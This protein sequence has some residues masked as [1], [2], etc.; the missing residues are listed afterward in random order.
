M[1]RTQYVSASV[2]ALHSASTK[3]LLAFVYRIAR[4]SV[5]FRPLETTLPGDGVTVGM[6]T[7]TIVSIASL[8][9]RAILYTVAQI[10]KDSGGGRETS[11]RWAVKGWL[12]PFI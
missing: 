4:L 8:I 5:R 1:P 9:A 2:I 11:E 3:P 12:K 7:W 6:S 10:T